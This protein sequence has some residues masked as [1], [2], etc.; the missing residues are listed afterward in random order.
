MNKK[1]GK[2]KIGSLKPRNLIN[3]PGTSNPVTPPP[4]RKLCCMFSEYISFLGVK[5]DKGV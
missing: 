5:L 2:L 3:N 4:L 1:I